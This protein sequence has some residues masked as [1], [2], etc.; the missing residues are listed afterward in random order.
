MVLAGGSPLLSGSR[1]RASKRHGDDRYDEQN[2]RS[3][4]DCGG[5]GKAM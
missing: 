1:S 3:D 2:G 4:D 5:S